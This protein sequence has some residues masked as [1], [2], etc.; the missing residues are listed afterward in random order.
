VDTAGNA[1]AERGVSATVNQPPDYI[2][3]TDWQADLSGGTLSNAL[4]ETGRVV[5]PVNTTETYAEHFTTPE[6]DW[7]TP[8]DQVD[9]GFD[10]FI[11]PVPASGYYEETFDYGAVINS[12]TMISA[13]LSSVAVD[14]AP[15]I[16]PKLSV[17][18][19]GTD[20]TDHDG[21]WQAMDSSFR[22]V[23]IRITVGSTGGDDLLVITGIRI[24]L[25]LKE[26]KDSGNAT[27]NSGDA[28]G[29]QVDFNISFIDVQS[30]TI[31]PIVTGTPGS[32]PIAVVED[33]L[34]VP[35][36]THFHVY[37]YDYAGTRLS[38]DFSWAAKGV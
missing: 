7:A 1:G 19:N 15:V 37:L 21:V 20:W 2:I 38:G 27:A 13:L 28:G 22:Y 16:T 24:L 25:D 34:D 18:A 10:I 4:Y 6:P 9:A 14:G 5:L 17:S 31:T 8:Q 12:N 3:L 30:I 23:K 35:Y 32:I 36:P 26:K 29:T 11:E 33:F